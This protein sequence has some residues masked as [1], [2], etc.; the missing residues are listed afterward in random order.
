M[1]NASL[2][3]AIAL[4]GGCATSGEDAAGN[5]TFI[6]NVA[7]NGI[8]QWRAVSKDRLY[9]RAVTGEWYL[10]RTMGT[11]STLTQ[12]LSLGFEPSAQGRLDRYGAILAE[13]RR[14]PVESVTRSEAPPPKTR[15]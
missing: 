13:G 12:A 11:C 4:I 9:I 10:V 15:K 1:R 6:P 8:A 14:C 2:L 3:A 5:E 7:G